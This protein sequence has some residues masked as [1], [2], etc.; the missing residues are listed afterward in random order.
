MGVQQ[1]HPND[2]V[3][4]NLHSRSAAPS[5]TQQGAFLSASPSANVPYR[6]ASGSGLE[7]CDMCGWRP[8][9]FRRGGRS[10][11]SA[12]RRHRDQVRARRGRARGRQVPVWRTG[13]E[14][15]AGPFA[16]RCEGG[17]DRAGTASDSGD[18]LASVFV[19]LQ[20]GSTWVPS[21]RRRWRYSP[22]D[23]PTRRHARW[24][25]WSAVIW[26]GRE[27]RRGGVLRADDVTD[28]GAIAL[29]VDRS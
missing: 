13:V 23:R 11:R 28:R 26:T 17:S 4:T 10:K 19:Q 18:P 7:C 27:F 15:G 12:P 9:L 14:G 3:R 5:P 20:P 8:R 22:S 21:F 1:T 29:L 16:P 25:F 6:A 24:G 2:E